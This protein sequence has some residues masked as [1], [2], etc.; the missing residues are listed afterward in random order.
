[1]SSSIRP[2][3]PRSVVFLSTS[4][5]LGKDGNVAAP[6]SRMILNNG[7]FNRARAEIS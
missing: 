5:F 4:L 3:H 6:N 1:V 7:S 2:E